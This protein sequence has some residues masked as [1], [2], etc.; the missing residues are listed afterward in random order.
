MRATL[1]AHPTTPCPFIETFEV[2]VQRNDPRGLVIGYVITGDIDK[3]SI[4]PKRPAARVD[5]LWEHTCFEIFLRARGARSYLELNFSPSTEWAAYRFDDHR[6]GVKELSMP[7][8]PQIF[9]DEGTA[10]VMDLEVALE[11]KALR[12]FADSDIQLGASAVIE[13]R[14]GRKYYWA[15]RHP[16]GKPDFHHS[17][18]FA[19]TLPNAGART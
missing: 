16:P 15:L 18:S 19:L 7:N 4:P 5:Q 14:D 9:H 1:I 11:L 10:H 2:V 8:A 6:A 3:I 12:V 13:D 17:D